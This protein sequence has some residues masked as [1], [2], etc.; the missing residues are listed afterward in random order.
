MSVHTV[1]N[2]GMFSEKQTVTGV[3]GSSC[4]LLWYYPRICLIWLWKTTTH[5]RKN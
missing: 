3:E 4:L 5:F 1:T 2:D